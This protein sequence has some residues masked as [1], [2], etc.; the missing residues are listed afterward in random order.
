MVLDRVAQPFAFRPIARIG[1]D[2]A[3]PLAAIVIAG[4]EIDRHRQLAELLA[5]HAV[6]V[7]RAAID[8]IAGRQHDIGHRLERVERAHGACQHGVGLDDAVGLPAARPD[9]QV[10]NLRDDH[11]DGTP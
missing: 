1:E 9:V 2:L 5:Q 6:L 4:D 3:Q 8:E 11:A 7:D 10:G